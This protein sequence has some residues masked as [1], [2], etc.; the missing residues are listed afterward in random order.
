VA[1]II[2]RQWVIF[3]SGSLLFSRALSAREAQDGA[4]G[5]W[6]F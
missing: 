1:S 3:N 2:E 4:T 6:D 5:L